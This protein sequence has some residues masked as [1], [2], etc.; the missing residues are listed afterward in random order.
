MLDA[1]AKNVWLLLTL[2]I[3]GL[4]TTIF[5]MSNA[6]WVIEECKKTNPGGMS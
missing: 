1:V 3:P 4:F 2:V 6:K 5:R